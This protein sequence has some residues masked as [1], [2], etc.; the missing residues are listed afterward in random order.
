[1]SPVASRIVV[2]E[3]AGTRELDTPLAVGGAG[4]TVVVPG[5]GDG[6]AIIFEHD[7]ADW[8]IAPASTASMDP[9]AVARLNGERLRDARDLRD[10][11]VIGLGEAELRVRLSRS[12]AV[13]LLVA[14]LAGNT[15]VAPLVPLPERD[16]APEDD[17]VDI[18]AP[19]PSGAAPQGGAGAQ[20]AG[21]AA[22]RLA[23]A[24]I[25]VLVALA[26]VLLTRLERV[27]LELD[28]AEAQVSTPGTLLSWH[29]GATL[30]VWPGTHRVRAEAPGYLPADG[31]LKVER[32]KP[33]RLALRLAM[34][35]GVLVI[36]TAGVA[37]KVRVDGAEAGEAPGEIAAAA[38][39]R[40]LTIRADRYLDAVVTLEVQ[41]RGERQ[42]VK[43]ELQPSW[44]VLEVATT[45]P[46]ASVTVDGA[47]QGAT[48]TRLELPAG[49]RRLRLEA[50]G[51]KPWESAVLVKAGET[52]TVGPVTLGAPDAR[53]VVRS[54][55]GG[56]DVTVDGTYRG[57]TPLDIEVAPDTP[58]DVLVARTGHEPWSRTVQGAS[59]ERVA[60]EA[61]LV[62]IL[63]SL[64]VRGEPADAELVVD[65]APRGRTP[66]TLELTAGDHRVEVRKEGLAPFATTLTLAPGVART[67]EYTLTEPGRA[68][69][70]L[71]QGHRVTHPIG[72]ALRLVKPATF[73]F[74]S[75]RREQGRRPNEG[76]RR[77]TLTR[78]F[79]IGVYEV[80]NAEFR[81]FRAEHD[82]GYTGRSTQDLDTQPVARVTWGQAVEFC[83]W[84]SQQEGLP[85]AYERQGGNWVLK[86]PVSN[87]YRLPSEAEWEYAARYAGPGV[88]RRYPWGNELPVRENAANIA[89]VESRGLVDTVLETYRDDQPGVARV[90]QFAA[91]PLGLHDMAGNMTEWVHDGYASFFDAGPVVD[92]FGPAEGTRR[93]V[94]GSNWR[95]ASVA[96][97]RFAWRD[98]A[99]EASPTI[100]F[101]VA[102]YADP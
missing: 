97:L 47:P 52:V 29:S 30:F 101:R 50:S 43:V 84:L 98:G 51:T 65:G 100:G 24:A 67:L 75:E 45:V 17:D 91:N 5:I 11:D 2:V 89:G 62:P 77:V 82:S 63:V 86:T 19:S 76:R 72:L 6:A 22:R 85:P 69:N 49:V 34:R 57:R 38:G 9:V 99:D 48:P 8:R 33:A 27:A 56:A 10:G 4:A 15:T 102:R 78:A 83:N 93:V 60:L 32:G 81:R 55:P 59:G 3:P 80:T 21:R 42:D 41:G 90:G 7:G 66:A 20:P 87:G 88:L 58:H 74:G 28:P 68:S 44:G 23:V 12:G 1:M 35:P 70:A 13:E 18:T 16:A 73:E 53:L 96:D 54:V 92:P 40:T 26:F 31:T 64:T 46:G 71:P 94:R 14:H 79:Y 25:L 39:R 36:D 61:R 95:T 37:A